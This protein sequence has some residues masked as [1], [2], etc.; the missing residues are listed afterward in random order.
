[1]TQLDKLIV[2]INDRLST[3]GLSLSEFGKQ[4]VAE[5]F[6]KSESQGGYSDYWRN[7]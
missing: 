4:E 6:S 1:M 3:A 2:Y 5:R 7:L